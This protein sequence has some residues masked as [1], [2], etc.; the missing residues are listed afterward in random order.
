MSSSAWSV[1]GRLSVERGDC[2]LSR[3]KQQAALLQ[4]AARHEDE[5]KRLERGGAIVS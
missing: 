1:A 4:A 2:Q 5:L 3:V